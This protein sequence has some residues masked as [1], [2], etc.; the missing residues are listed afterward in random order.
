MFRVW[1]TDISPALPKMARAGT[2]SGRV[3]DVMPRVGTERGG[4]KAESL[5]VIEKICI[6]GR[7]GR[8]VIPGMIK[9][10]RGAV[11]LPLIADVTLQNHGVGPDP[12][13]RGAGKGI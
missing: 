4:R 10:I 6:Q 13:G 1:T 11:G 8:M 3:A 12:E 9:E 2:E 5:G 7:R